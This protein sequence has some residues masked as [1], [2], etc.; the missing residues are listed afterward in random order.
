[1]NSPRILLGISLVLLSAALA[2]AE[3]APKPVPPPSPLFKDQ[4]ANGRMCVAKVSRPN[5]E[6]RMEKGEKFLIA[7]YT[8]RRAYAVVGGETRY[9]E[10]LSNGVTERKVIRG[11]TL[12]T[13]NSKGDLFYGPSAEGGEVFQ[14]F[15]PELDWVRAE[16]L[17]GLEVI[18]GRPCYVYEE[19]KGETVLQ[20]LEVTADDLLPLEY[21]R[22]K[23][24]VY[25]YTYSRAD[26]KSI[27]LSSKVT[28]LLEKWTGTAR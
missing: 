11:E 3:P 8:L 1:M 6:K 25:T 20:R 9:E 23:S 13:E 28:E 12:F 15:F 4:L 17:L 21:A 22:G 7:P 18:Q 27:P 5:L 26:E 16:H 10:S 19:R 14:S 24:K 2:C